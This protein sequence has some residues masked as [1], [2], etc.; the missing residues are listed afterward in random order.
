MSLKY[1]IIKIQNWMRHLRFMV[2]YYSFKNKDPVNSR[3]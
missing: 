3:G 1:R 2:Q